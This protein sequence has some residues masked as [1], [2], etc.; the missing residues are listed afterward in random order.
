M[1]AKFSNIILSSK[2][3]LSLSILLHKAPMFN[4]LINTTLLVFFSNCT[5]KYNY[6][7]KLNQLIIVNIKV[8]SK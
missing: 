8:Y 7:L 4:R 6:S 3:K 5:V 2:S 1:L